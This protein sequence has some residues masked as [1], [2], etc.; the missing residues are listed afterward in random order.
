MGR[1]LTDAKHHVERI[2]YYHENAPFRGYA[3][4]YPHYSKLDELM[5]RAEKSKSDKR[6]VAAIQELRESVSD[7][8]EEMRKRDGV[9]E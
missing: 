3:Q 1:F 5:S 9:E 4:A 8:M 7:L 2:Q 6:D